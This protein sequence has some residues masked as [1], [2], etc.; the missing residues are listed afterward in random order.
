[1]SVK[2]R[3]YKV[4]RIWNDVDAV[5]KGR[6]GKR[7]RRR[8]AG[9]ATGKMFKKLTLLRSVVDIAIRCRWTLS[10]DPDGLVSTLATKADFISFLD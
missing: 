1:M 5:R 2:S 9:K 6:A 7:V 4:L 8:V 3:I 10:D